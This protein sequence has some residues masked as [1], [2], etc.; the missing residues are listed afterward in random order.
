MTPI[1]GVPS[2]TKRRIRLGPILAEPETAQQPD[3]GGIR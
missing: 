2:S 1:V 3:V